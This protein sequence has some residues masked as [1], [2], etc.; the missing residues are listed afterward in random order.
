MGVLKMHKSTLIIAAAMANLATPD[1][2]QIITPKTK[3]PGRTVYRSNKPY[4]KQ[5][6]SIGRNEPCPCHS[7]KKF[8]QC[9]LLIKE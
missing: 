4:I 8:K 6:K 2:G 7:G 1:V 9:H 3:R 5:N